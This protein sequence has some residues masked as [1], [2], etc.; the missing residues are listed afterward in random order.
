M[1]YISGLHVYVLKAIF[2][3]CVMDAIKSNLYKGAI[4][5]KFDLKKLKNKHKYWDAINILCH[6]RG[7]LAFSSCQAS[8]EG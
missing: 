1:V 7:G 2:N 6:K 5:R 3:S 4:N 8:G